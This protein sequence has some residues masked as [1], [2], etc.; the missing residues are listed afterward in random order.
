MMYTSIKYIY[1][2]KKF[3]S[4]VYSYLNSIFAYTKGFS[5]LM[6]QLNYNDNNNNNI[7]YQL[8]MPILSEIYTAL[9]YIYF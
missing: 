6:F 8:I 3:I 1:F 7:K 9:D 2:N 5:L 4:F